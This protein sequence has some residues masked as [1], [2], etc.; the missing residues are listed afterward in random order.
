MKRA[1]I[2]GLSS[3]VCCALI[4]ITISA[5]ADPAG[6]V[7]LTVTA[8]VIDQQQARHLAG[9]VRS[10]VKQR[11]LRPELR[12]VLVLRNTPPPDV[13][14]P[15][16]G[17]STAGKGVHPGADQQ[18]EPEY[19]TR[20]RK[21]VAKRVKK[22]KRAKK[23]KACKVEPKGIDISKR[24]ME[25]AAR[26]SPGT[27]PAAGASAS[28]G[29]RGHGSGRLHAKPK[30]PGVGSG[31]GAKAGAGT[32]RGTGAGAGAGSKRGAGAGTGSAGGTGSGSKLG[33]GKGAGSS[34][35]SGIRGG[36]AGAGGGAGGGSG[37]KKGG[38]GHSRR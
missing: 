29:T 10:A 30:T 24:L 20:T 22:A 28:R 6:L 16:T 27:T 36:G 3:C 26:L 23:A 12:P 14:E 21:R 25:D 35:G 33:T 34:K 17:P 32:G 31:R 8:E 19:I 2:I 13:E 5:T 7:D 38:G 11:A 18:Y 4:M 9:Q 37:M 15:A 1:S